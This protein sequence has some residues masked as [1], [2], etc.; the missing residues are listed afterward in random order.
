MPVHP[1]DK[2]LGSSSHDVVARARRLLGTRR[3]GH[4]GTLDPLATGVL[5]LLS[6]EA[7]KLSPFLT[8]SDKEYLAWVAFGLGT[9]TLDAEPP[10]DDGKLT[11][12]APDALAALTQE[13][14]ANAA[15]AFLGLTEQRPPA[16]SA[17]KQGGTR[18]YAAARRGEAT[19]PP[20]RPVAYRRVEVL[21]FAPRR[22]DLPAGFAPRSAAG[23][24]APGAATTARR[25]AWRPSTA[26][27]SRGFDL[28]PELAEL[29]CALVAVTVAAGTYVR[30]FARD[31]GAC[32]GVPA[33]LA[34]LVRVRAGKVDLADCSPLDTV[35]SAAPLDP[36]ALLPYPRAPLD[37]R[38]ATAVRQGKQ[39]ELGLTGTTALVDE[40]GNL[41]A[42]VEPG[43]DGRVRYARVWQRGM[44]P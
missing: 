22:G 13:G 33:H 38:T 19:E 34:G 16:F 8:A 26:P 1:V 25:S 32:L 5:V 44:T 35:A 4:A 21:G 43:P 24:P 41:A 10:E 42:I 14:V 31:L 28:P 9:P 40:E 23:D 6:E 15:R 3:V 36:V 37:D 30:S 7:T 27:G 20:A 17:I 12:A 11:R 29:P 2:P 18:S 39:V